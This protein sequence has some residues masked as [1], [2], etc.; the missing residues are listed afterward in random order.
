MNKL[1]DYP[2]LQI[3]H[4][5]FFFLTDKRL[6]TYSNNSASTVPNIQYLMLSS[7]NYK[8]RCVIQVYLQD[9]LRNT[10]IND[11]EIICY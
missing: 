7:R 8:H 3:F 6:C 4:G 2:T 1:H 5:G 11:N 10:I 9:V